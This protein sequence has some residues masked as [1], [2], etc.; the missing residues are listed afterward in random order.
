MSTVA[1]AAQGLSK[2][3]QRGS[4]RADTLRDA[5]CN[6]YRR[7]LRRDEPERTFWALRDTSFEVEPGEIVGIIGR[8]GAGKSTLLKI[9][10]RITAPTSGRALIHGRLASLLEV[11]TGFHPELTGRENVF[12]NGAILG[13]PKAEIVRQLEPIIEWA[14]VGA[15]ADTPVKRYSSGMRVRLAFSVAVHLDAQIL[16]L[17]EVLAVGDN[18]FQ[19]KCLGKMGEVA[20]DGRTVLLVSHN[21]NAVLNL[22]TRG[23]VLEQGRLTYDG[24][25]HDAVRTYTQEVRRPGQ[26]FVHLH[27]AAG[28]S[29]TGRAIVRGVGIRRI[30]EAEYRDCVNT[31]DN[32]AFDV[33]FDCGSDTVDVAQLTICTTEGQ[34]LLTV[35]THLT[36]SAPQRLR[37]QGVL[38]CEL[39]QLPLNVGQYDLTVKVSNRIP[40]QDVDCVEAALRFEVEP[41]DYFGTGL[42]PGA[43]QGPVAHRAAWRLLPTTMP[44]RHER[45]GELVTA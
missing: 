37:G 41:N 25:I 28:R 14:G 23:I 11:G 9:L 42:R 29:G 27:G 5:L 32:L 17:D 18:E 45:E 20:K 13:M 1:I 31:G 7:A 10:T 2:Q 24:D 30:G 26:Q 36:S 6:V 15:F 4:R 39:R 21:M 16:I 8:N 19:K 33:E 44:S 40:W 34:P 38:S 3:Y 22:C 12:L 35:G 43:E